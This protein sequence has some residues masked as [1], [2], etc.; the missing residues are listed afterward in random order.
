VQAF[1]PQ[2]NQPPYLVGL[3]QVLKKKKILPWSE[4]EGPSLAS[5]TFATAIRM[6]P[7]TEGFYAVLKT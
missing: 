6:L 4:I 3:L 7:F 2:V 1:P 5:A